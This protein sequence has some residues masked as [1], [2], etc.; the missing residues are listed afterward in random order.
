MGLTWNLTKQQNLKNHRGT[1]KTSKT[2]LRTLVVPESNELPLE[3]AG[4]KSVLKSGSRTVLDHMKTPHR[5]KAL[6]KRS[7]SNPVSERRVLD[8]PKSSSL[9]STGSRPQRHGVPRPCSLHRRASKRED[10]RRLQV[11]SEVPSDRG[12]RRVPQRHRH[13]RP[14]PRGPRTGPDSCGTG[15]DSE[16][17]AECPSLLHSTVPDSSED[18]RSNCTTDHFGDSESSQ[19]QDQDRSVDED[20]QEGVGGGP[21]VRGRGARRPGPKQDPSLTKTLVKIKVSHNLKKKILR[22]RSGSLKLMTTV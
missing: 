4:G 22:S 10:H 2:V 3:T 14:V 13:L 20:P 21:A 17:S 6:R 9:Q 19:D 16:Y 11:I 15:S 18:D 1:G 7:V 12:T 5:A 8:K